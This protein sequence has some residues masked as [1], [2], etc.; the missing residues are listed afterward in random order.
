[1]LLLYVTELNVEEI[2]GESIA[3]GPE[4]VVR[5]TC[6][7]LRGPGEEEPE[8]MVSK[9]LVESIVRG[10]KHDEWSAFCLLASTI[11]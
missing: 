5:D 1:M 3:R 6:S 7:T 2:L 9:A 11:Q 10:A 8:P 4:G